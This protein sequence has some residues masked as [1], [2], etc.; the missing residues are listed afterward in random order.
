MFATVRS[1]CS[2]SRIAALRQLDDPR[3]TTT[4]LASPLK[5]RYDVNK[6]RRFHSQ[7]ITKEP[8]AGTL[9]EFWVVAWVLG[10]STSMHRVQNR[11]WCF[12]LARYETYPF[13]IALEQPRHRGMVPSLF[14]RSRSVESSGGYVLVSQSVATHRES[15]RET[16]E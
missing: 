12:H 3:A 11:A 16:T 13:G 10:S 4:A 1:L 7:S 2:V 8:L 5:E 15:T 9:V 14:Y 6:R